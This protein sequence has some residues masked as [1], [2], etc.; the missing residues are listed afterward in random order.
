MEI[1]YLLIGGI[2]STIGAISGLGGGVIIKPILDAFGHFD[3]ATI[4]I[5]SSCTVFA[6]TIVSL[7][8]KFI[9][10]ATFEYSKLLPLSFGAII[11]GFFGK[12]LFEKF[13]QIIPNQELGKMI[14]AICLLILMLIIL[15][16]GLNRHKIK[17]YN[18]TNSIV[19]GISG[20]IMGVISSF[21]G[22]GGGPVNVALL[23][24]LFSCN[25]KEAALYSIFTIFFSQLSTLGSVYFSEGFATYNLTVLP[26]MIFGGIVGGFLGSFFNKKLSTQY[27]EKM[28]NGVMA[29]TI[30]INGYNILT[31]II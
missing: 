15:L 23:I 19:C 27:V 9:E 1:L 31:V 5:L 4:G 11:G 22:I 20:I 16:F 7:A 6:M 10:K 28:F 12:Y 21:L 2:A 30:L 13:L 17:T 26:Y 18:I 25:A 8:K 14:Q 24:L 3:I 29:A